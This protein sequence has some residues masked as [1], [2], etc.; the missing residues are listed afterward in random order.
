MCNSVT[1]L[2]LLESQTG[3]YRDEWQDVADEDGN[4]PGSRTAGRKAASLETRIGSRLRPLHWLAHALQATPEA[5]DQAGELLQILF[6]GHATADCS[7]CRLPA[8]RC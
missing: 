4:T 1:E 5:T 2:A 3:R 6:G 7:D 8:R